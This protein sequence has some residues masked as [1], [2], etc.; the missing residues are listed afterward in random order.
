MR[1]ASGPESVKRGKRGKTRKEKASGRK[2][3]EQKCK[4]RNRE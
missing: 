2:E 3:E 4:M 1:I